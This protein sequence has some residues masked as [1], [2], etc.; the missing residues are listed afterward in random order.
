[1]RLIAA[2]VVFVLPTVASAQDARPKRADVV[3][4]I[5]RGLGFLVKDAQA[6]KKD[7]NCASCHHASLVICSLREAKRFG[8]AVDEPVLA[9][10]TK[11]VAESGDGKFGLARPAEAP[12]AASPKAIYFALALGADPKPDEASQKGLK[13]L[14]KTVE[15]EQTENG[16]W[17]AWP[18]TRPPIFGNSDESLTALATL[19]VLPAAATG[20]DSAKA[21][22]DRAIR[23]L[24]ETKTDDDPQ[25][26]A[27]RL[28]LWT[29]LGRPSKEGE[30]LVK[31]IKDRQNADGG[32]SQ[33]KDMAS[34]AWA[35]GQALYALAHAGAKSYEP[36]I[37]RAHAFLIKTQRADGSWPMTSRPVKPGGEG[38]KSLIPITGAGSAWAV[39]GLVRSR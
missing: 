18:A 6:W 32:W 25:S 35:T 16:S 24:T 17:S 15:S 2:S 39:L 26:I 22:R 8:H 11:W 20:D 19:A 7:H 4:A 5:G 14:L 30:P 34:D 38:S 27:L 33:T 29:R 31:R 3:A 1:M 36:A 12:R 37:T 23:W 28:V 21:V 13:L 9:E 10:L